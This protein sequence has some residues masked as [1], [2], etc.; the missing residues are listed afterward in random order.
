MP[1]KELSVHKSDNESSTDL[2]AEEQCMREDTC[3]KWSQ[4]YDAGSGIKS[5]MED[6][7][8][9]LIKAVTESSTAAM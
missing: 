2:E 6:Q 9:W 5:G 8:Q 7:L 3:T 1:Q 4:E